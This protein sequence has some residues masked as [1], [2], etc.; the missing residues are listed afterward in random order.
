[1][2]TLVNVLMKG[3]WEYSS[4]KQYFKAEIPEGFIRMI[5]FL[6]SAT[7]KYNKTEEYFIYVFKQLMSFQDAH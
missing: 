4:F 5:F 3:L 2:D 1:M 7:V 6:F